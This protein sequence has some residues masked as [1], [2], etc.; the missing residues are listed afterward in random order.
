MWGSIV[1]RFSVYSVFPGLSFKRASLLKVEISAELVQSLRKSLWVTL[2]DLEL[3]EE[4]VP[5]KSEE[6][7][8]SDHFHSFAIHRSEEWEIEIKRTVGGFL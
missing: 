5:S 2:D 8:A 3:S 6:C 4:D 7:S 1:L